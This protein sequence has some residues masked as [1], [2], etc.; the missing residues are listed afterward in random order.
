M[1]TKKYLSLEKLIEYDT[2]IKAEIAESETNAKTYTDNV[3]ND[4]LNGAGEAY[5]TLKEL[6]D[7]I[8]DNTD[9]IDA[10]EIVAT[11]K[12]NASDLTSHT[13]NT[14]NPHNV[15]YSQLGL[16]VDTWTFTLEDGSTVTK[17]MVV[18]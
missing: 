14:S 4:L 11:S 8:D 3:K 16:S 2:L 6:G 7:L 12:A 1:A 10:L 15:T 18:K 5:D 13:S 9:A 17:E